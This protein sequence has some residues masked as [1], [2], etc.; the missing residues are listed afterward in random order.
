MELSDNDEIHTG[1]R[2]FKVL[3]TPGH[4]LGHISLYEPEEEYLFVEISFIEM[5]SAGL[6]SLGKGF[7]SFKFD[8]N[9]K[10][11]IIIL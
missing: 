7:G 10:K 8:Y 3:H 6:T 2:T 1:N 9:M 5:M 4:T 11:Q